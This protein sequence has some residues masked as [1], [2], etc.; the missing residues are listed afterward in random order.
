M[1]ASNSI[2]PTRLLYSSPS[3]I[4]I[5]ANLYCILLSW[6]SSEN[7]ESNLPSRQTDLCHRIIIYQTFPLAYFTICVALHQTN[8]MELSFEYSLQS[9]HLRDCVI[10]FVTCD[11]IQCDLLSL[12]SSRWGECLLFYSKYDV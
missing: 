12:F 8:I 6:Q 3:R 11:Y 2:E 10:S 4:A 7:G 5:A 9:M 1:S